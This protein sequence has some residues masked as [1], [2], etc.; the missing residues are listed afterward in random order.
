MPWKLYIDSR[1]RVPHA[2]G[3]SHSDFA[4][5]LPYPIAVSGKCFIAVVL[6]T[7]SFYTIRAGEN[8]RIYLDETAANTKRIA[9]IAPGQYNVYELQAALIT[10]LTTNKLITGQYNVTYLPTVNKFQIDITNAAVSDSFHIWPE[11]YL[12]TNFV[13]WF[14]ISLFLDANDIQSANSVCGFIDGSLL[15]GDNN[16]AIIGPNS[17]DVQP[18]KQLFL[19][20]NLGGGSSESLGLNGETDIIRRLVVGNVPPNALIHDIHN[21]PLDCV[22]INGHPELMQL[23]FQLIDSDGK[24]VN[25]HGHP[26][27]FSVIFQD[28]DDY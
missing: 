4:I 20:S 14:A 11:T 1:K 24:V 12:K 13:S 17:P 19:R 16:T 25:T 18:Y 6:L 15:T 5:Q 21:Q 23:W 3:D 26:I 27:S 8:D 28:I 9:T 2:R 22:K 10:S 7:S